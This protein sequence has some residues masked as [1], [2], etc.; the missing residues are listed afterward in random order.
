MGQW[1]NPHRMSVN[2]WHE[3]GVCDTLDDIIKW[4]PI[5]CYWPFVWGIHQSP[6]N[7]PHKGQWRGALMFSLICAWIN[8]WVNN[9]QTGDLRCHR[10]HYDDT[11]MNHNK[12]KH[13]K[14]MYMYLVTYGTL[15]ILS[16]TF[17][18]LSDV[19]NMSDTDRL[20][21]TSTYFPGRHGTLAF[22]YGCCLVGPLQELHL[23][24]AVWNDVLPGGGH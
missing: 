19:H 20:N 17:H 16:S 21:K 8:S 14:T 9:R 5:P 22:W 24:W 10:V 23:A 6:V 15:E 18:H 11:V 2:I 4:K 13:K 1:N 7:S 3:L 12:R